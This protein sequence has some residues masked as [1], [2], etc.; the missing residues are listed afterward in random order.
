[1]TPSVPQ[2]EAPSVPAPI[3]PLAAER[4]PE[5]DLPDGG[6]VTLTIKGP[7][8]IAR[9][10]GSDPAPQFIQGRFEQE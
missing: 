10:D 9:S 8:H 4:L 5:T 1:P 6:N 3:A 7:V 2:F